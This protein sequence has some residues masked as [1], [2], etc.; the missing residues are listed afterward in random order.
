MQGGMI[1][2]DAALGHHLFDVAKAQGV[3]CVPAHAQQHH[4]ERIVHAEK[5]FS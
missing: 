2:E 3:G 5:H 1:D 4:F